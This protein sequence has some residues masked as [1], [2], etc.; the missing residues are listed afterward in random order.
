VTERPIMPDEK[1]LARDIVDTHHKIMRLEPDN[2]LQIRVWHLMV[3]LARLSKGE[4]WSLLDIAKDASQYM[5][6]HS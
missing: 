3:S 4:K 5:S 2:D 1:E 6:D